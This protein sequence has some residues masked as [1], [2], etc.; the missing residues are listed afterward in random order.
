MIARQIADRRKGGDNGDALALFLSLVASQVL[1]FGE[2]GRPFLV[3]AVSPIAS[4]FDC[5]LA[6][7]GDL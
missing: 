3:F 2:G 7:G 5:D 4:G 1:D 6:Q